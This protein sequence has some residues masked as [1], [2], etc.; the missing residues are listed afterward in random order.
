MTATIIDG[1]G[2]ADAIRGELRQRVAALK[3]KGVTPGLAVVLVGDDPASATY[4]RM[5]GK[6]CEDLG[7]YSETVIKSS[8]C[9]GEELL[10][11]I[12]RL[13]HDPKVHGFLVQM[14]LP[15]HIDP[16]KVI[17]RIDPRKDVDAFHP[18]NVGKMLIGEEDGF[19]PATPHGVQELLLRSGNDPAGK[20]VVI[21]GRSNIVGKPLA[22]LLMQKKV[23]ADATVTICHSRTRDL[24]DITRQADILIAAMGIPRFIRADMVKDGVVVIDVGT[25][26]VEDP[27]HPKG[28][29][30]VGDVDFDAVKEK[31]KAI[32]PVPKGVGPMT[33]VMLM[34]NTILAAERSLR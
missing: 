34:Q 12:D 2:V 29:R 10:A 14:P 25:N 31:A 22:A 30:L 17:E 28:S 33:I 27:S 24:S 7:L 15:K 3:T 19:L 13:N 4:V 5:K 26:R 9:S 6:A 32:T 21:C 8:D 23:G 16:N 1:T 18:I 20:H 11:V